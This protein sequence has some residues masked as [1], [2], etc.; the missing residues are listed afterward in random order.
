MTDPWTTYDED[1]PKTWPIDEGVCWVLG[2]DGSDVI[3]VTFIG[4]DDD[5]PTFRDFGYDLGPLYIFKWHA[6]PNMPTEAT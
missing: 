5:G 3:P 4:P 6:P 2:W 1:D